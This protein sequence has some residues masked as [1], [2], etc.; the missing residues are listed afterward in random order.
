MSPLILMIVNCL[1][2]PKDPNREF[3][4]KYFENNS[5]KPQAPTLRG[6]DLWNYLS[7]NPDR[8]QR[9]RERDAAKKRRRYQEASRLA[10]KA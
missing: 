2:F 6:G 5:T 1:Q 8:P 7:V 9:E 3:P 4:G 10:E